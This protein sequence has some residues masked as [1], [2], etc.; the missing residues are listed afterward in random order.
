MKA[1]KSGSRHRKS[2]V[3]NSTYSPQNSHNKINQDLRS[4]KTS[5]TNGSQWIEPNKG[6]KYQ[7][8]V[9]RE[10]PVL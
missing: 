5:N 2:G 4:I 3:S 1:K 6:R 7:F 9:A 8:E 10:P